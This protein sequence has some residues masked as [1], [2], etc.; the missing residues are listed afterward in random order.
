[1]SIMR[2]LK[3]VGIGYLQGTTD[4]MA[5][6][7]AQKRED[8][9]LA[10]DREYESK[11]Q[12]DRILQTKLANIEVNNEKFKNES[13]LATQKEQEDLKNRR[14][15]LLAQGYTVPMV[16]VLTEQGYLK[17]D[18]AFGIFFNKYNR[19]MFDLTG[20]PDWHTAVDSNGVSFQDLYVQS[21]QAIDTENVGMD[22]SSILQNYNN[23]SRNTV[24]SQ[25]E[26]FKPKVEDTTTPNY[27]AASGITQTQ[28]ILDLPAGSSAEAFSPTIR[29]DIA[30]QAATTQVE[31]TTPALSE[32][33]SFKTVKSSSGF[34]S[35]FSKPQLQQEIHI[36]G[37]DHPAWALTDIP[38]EALGEGESV[39]LTLSAD[40]T[41]YTSKII[42]LTDNYQ[43]LLTK[44]AQRDKTIVDAIKANSNLFNES[45]DIAQFLK[46]GKQ[47]EDYF[48]QNAQKQKLFVNVYDYASLLDTSYRVAQVNQEFTKP[49]QVVQNAIR[50]NN[51]V[52]MDNA[53]AYAVAVAEAQAKGLPVSAQA[54]ILLKGVNQVIREVNA[55]TAGIDRSTEEGQALISRIQEKALNEFKINAS[56]ATKGEGE[57]S[58]PLATGD[59]ATVQL[60]DEIITDIQKGPQGNKGKFYITR[61]IVK[62]QRAQEDTFT[63]GGIDAVP[64]GEEITDPDKKSPPEVTKFDFSKVPE[65]TAKSE[66]GLGVSRNPEYA[67]YF[68][69]FTQENFDNFDKEYENLKT[70]EP[71]KRIPRPPKNNIKMSGTIIN[72]EW[73]KWNESVKPYRDFYQQLLNYELQN[74]TKYTTQKTK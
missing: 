5:Q 21:Y 51:I 59:A 44:T 32:G 29:T 57:Q 55:A 24:E 16:D 39:K 15:N 11:L 26:D 40:G 41:G 20:N 53:T 31:T 48:A 13:N 22:S 54:D 65:K 71:Q 66:T 6:K 18:S 2:A 72:P 8:E 68:N 17:S 49:Q 23:M 45:E 36:V 1:M 46:G 64:I 28:N 67:E 70:K 34:L 27:E 3:N 12:K 7:A 56:F 69:N 62:E 30:N 50:L 74:D 42:K 63:T 37:K 47:I 38:R 52:G 73:S 43:D 60:I 19:A 33:E 14:N 58:G 10:A 4:I 9:K 35:T 61:G 25:L